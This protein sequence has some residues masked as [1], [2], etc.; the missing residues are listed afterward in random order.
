MKSII[1]P[2]FFLVGIGGLTACVTVKPAVDKIG[3]VV[4]VFEADYQKVWRATMLALEDYPIEEENNEKGYLKT[5]LIQEN[6]LWKPPFVVKTTEG[7]YR[8]I[9]KITKG[10]LEESSVVQVRIWK[11]IMVQKGFIAD[12]ERVPSS[13]LEEKAILYRIFREVKI[14]KGIANYYQKKANKPSN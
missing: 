5:E 9:I 10:Q 1:T 8:L 12:L 7:K 13:G 6:T 4:R 11:Q 2:L 14:E 3:P